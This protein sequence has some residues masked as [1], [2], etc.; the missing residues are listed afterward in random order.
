[1][2]SFS[3]HILD[4]LCEKGLDITNGKLIVNNW[5]IGFLPLGTNCQWLISA[6]DDQHYVNL[7]FES[8]NVRTY[9]LNHLSCLSFLSFI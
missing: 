2:I 6:V 9:E 4:N 7:E 1:M 5:L 3:T 8:F